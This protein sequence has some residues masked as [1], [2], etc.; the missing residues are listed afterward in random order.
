MNIN[1]ENLNKIDEI[2]KLLNQ[3]HLN[4]STQSSKKWLSVKELWIYLDYSKDRIHKLKGVEFFDG[5]HYYKRSW[6]LLFDKDMIDKWVVWID[7]K[8]INWTVD[9]Q[10]TVNNI[11]DW[12]LN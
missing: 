10:D 8:N 12:I 7:T 5:V 2:L 4:Q 1:F 6:K 3:I 11:L 9:V